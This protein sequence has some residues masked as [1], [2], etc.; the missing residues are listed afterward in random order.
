MRIVTAK[1]EDA[2]L[3]ADAILAAV[4]DDIVEH[5]AGD[6]HTRD[7]VHGIF[8]RLAASDDTQYSYLNSRIALDD[9]GSPL[10]VCVSYDGADLKR[11]RRPFFREANEILGW[12]MTDEEIENVPGETDSDEFYLDTLMVLPEYRR[13]GVAGALI[14]DA[15]RKAEAAGK[16]LGLLC[17]TDNDNARHLY[18]KSGFRPVGLRP[19][20]GHDMTHMQLTPAIPSNPLK[21]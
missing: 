10:G 21:V 11:L 9:S 14:A 3:I 19:F 12:G 4:G 8:A 2:S 7:D 15:A 6:R 16:P 5:L 1:R 20:A 13:R 18:D 17:D